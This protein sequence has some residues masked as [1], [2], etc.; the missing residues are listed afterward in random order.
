METKWNRREILKAGATGAAYSLLG[1]TL[2]A[3]AQETEPPML[4][5]RNG[6]FTTL[7][8]AQPAASAVALA[9]GRFAAVGDEKEV[10]KLA[11][12]KTQVIDLDLAAYFDTVRHD[13]LLGKVAQRVQDG[14]ILHLL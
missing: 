14:E 10:M 8:Q 5:L 3:R 11:G 2:A 13:L 6:K 4:I 7:D 9:D 12:P 1:T